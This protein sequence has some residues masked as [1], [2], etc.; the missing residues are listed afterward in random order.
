MVSIQNIRQH[1]KFQIGIG[2]GVDETVKLK[3]LPIDDTLSQAHKCRYI[4]Y[5]TESYQKITTTFPDIEILYDAATKPETPAPGLKHSHDIAPIADCKTSS[6]LQLQ[7]ENE[8][9]AL[10]FGKFVNKNGFHATMIK[11][12]PNQKMNLKH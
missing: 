8:H 11:T 1:N 5:N 9:K 7:S 4:D 6:A 10:N 2:F 12:K 3:A